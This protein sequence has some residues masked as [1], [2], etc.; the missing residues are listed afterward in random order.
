MELPTPRLLLRSPRPADLE[1]WSAIL[2]EPEVA[3]F[4]P[5]YDRARIHA[6]LLTPS[7]V[8]VLT[9]EGS[10]ESGAAGAVL[11]AIQYEQS[12][13]PEYRH[14]GVDLFVGARGQGRGLGSEAIRA[15]VEHLFG[16]LGH[17]RIVI[18]PAVHNQRAIRVYERLGFRAVGLLRQ[19][20]RGAD[21]S[22]HDGLLMELLASDYRPVP[23]ARSALAFA[24]PLFLQAA[25]P[26]DVP[27]LLAMMVDFNQGEAIDWDSERGEAPLRHLLAHPELGQV[28]L[29]Q[30]GAQPIGYGVVTYGYD[31]EFSGRDAFLTE[32]Y[33]APAARGQGQGRRALDLLLAA[34]R[35]QGAR[36]LHLQVRPD[37]PAALRLYLAAGFKG[38]TRTFLSKS[39][40]PES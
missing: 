37:N 15:V 24:P 13:E 12:D 7:E 17:H 40:L 18:D 25:T 38:T 16:R 10:A 32:F 36:A 33:L 19:Y 9:I 23:A 35:A 30:Q 2:Q 3:R 14:A 8:T 20:E 22:F 27:V 31:L 11:G 28:S 6:E 5:G 34:A 39:L 21:G 1:P 4:W 29:L 26:A